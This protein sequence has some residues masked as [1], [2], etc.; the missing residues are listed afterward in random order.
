MIKYSYLKNF[1]KNN[2]FVKINNFLDYNT[3]TKL[4]SYVNQ[5]E[6]DKQLN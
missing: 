2:G 3:K 1:Y 6:N 5:I 4:L